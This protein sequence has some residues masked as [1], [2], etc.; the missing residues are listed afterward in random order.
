MNYNP[1]D[2]SDI[3]PLSTATDFDP[4]FNADDMQSLNNAPQNQSSMM[5]HIK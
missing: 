3:K 5:N 2:V 4:V 1:N